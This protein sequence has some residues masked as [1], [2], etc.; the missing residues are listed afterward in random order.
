MSQRFLH[1]YWKIGIVGIIVGV[2]CVIAIGF[3]RSVNGG[4]SEDRISHPR[5]EVTAGGLACEDAVW[6]IGRVDATDSPRLSHT[7]M[8]H[9]RSDQAIQLKK[10]LS[11]CGCL[12]ADGYERNILPGNFCEL[13]AAITVPS[14]V[15][16]FSQQLAVG[17]ECK[18]TEWMKLTV[19]GIG[20][21]NASLY[22]LPRVVNFGTMRL[23]DVRTRTVRIARRDG[24]EVRVKSARCEGQGLTVLG[25]LPFSET[26]GL[27]EITL[28]LDSNQLSPK[29]LIAYYATIDTDHRRFTD[30]RVHVAGVIAS[31]D[32]SD[33]VYPG[34]QSGDSE[35]S[36][37]VQLMSH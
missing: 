1:R 26:D 2:V 14:E 23:G 36:K 27:A 21:V 25:E 11:S 17:V 19:V 5:I 8:L 13:T 30:L 9:N 15:G 32:G 33:A 6:D 3:F 28:R 34:H 4:Y 20:K 22:S 24:S 10:V 37:E 18:D 12:V 31:Q 35:E 16:P 7:F 29:E